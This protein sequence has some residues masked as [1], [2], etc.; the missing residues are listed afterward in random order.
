MHDN[1]CNNTR[2]NYQVRENPSPIIFKYNIL[3]K[4]HLFLMCISSTTT[5]LGCFTDTLY[6]KK[7]LKA[8]KEIK[9]FSA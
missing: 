8:K 9:P 1:N 5:N 7:N 3:H 2:T 6:E 4:H